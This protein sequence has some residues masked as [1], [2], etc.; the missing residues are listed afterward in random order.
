MS[1]YSPPQPAIGNP[2]DFRFM[3]AALVLILSAIIAA[4]SILMVGPQIIVIVLLALVLGIIFAVRRSFWSLVCFGYPFTYGLIVAWIGYHETLGYE[5]TTPFA[6]SVGIGLFACVLIAV[7]LWK[8]LPDGKSKEAV[9][10][11]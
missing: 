2:R 6:I 8:S 5:K 11:N 1:P 4:S 10:G 3:R 7:G 9:S